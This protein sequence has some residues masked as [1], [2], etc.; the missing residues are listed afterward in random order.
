MNSLNTWTPNGLTV[1][2]VYERSQLSQ[3]RMKTFLENAKVLDQHTHG[4]VF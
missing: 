3:K 4:N 1:C 2:K